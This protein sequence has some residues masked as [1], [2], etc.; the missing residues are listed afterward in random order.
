MR[1]ISYITM[2]VAV[3]TISAS[4][5]A[6]QNL[7]QKEAITS[8]EILEDGSVIIRLYAPKAESVTLYGDFAPGYDSASMTMTRTD[9]GVWEYRSEPLASELYYYWFNVDGIDHIV[10]P[11]N[12][13]VM[14]DVGSQMNYFI[15][16]GERGDLYSAQS[17]P[18][19]TV[20]KV[21]AKISDG[22]ERRMTVYTPAGYE[23]GRSKYPVLYLLH[24]MGGDEEAWI[25]T[26]RL[27]EI[28]DNL[29][30]QG[31]AEPMIVVMTNGCTNHVSAPGFS[32]EGMWRPYMSG[33]MDGSFERMFPSIVEWVDTHYRTIGKKSSRAIAGLSMG[34]FH[35]MQISK[36]YPTMFDYVGL[37][38]AAIF[39]GKEGVEIYDNLE[40]KLA[41]QFEQGVQKYW[42]AIGND[43]FLY[44]EN[45]RYRELLNSYGYSYE[46]RES[47]KGHIWRNWRIYIAEFAQM[48]FSN[49]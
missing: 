35:A 41:R 11:A 29:I 28:M 40:T 17:V 14:R 36:E 27:A 12:S 2:I 42:I 10:D 13:Y 37:F 1:F 21:W 7:W 23:G 20:S 46:Y 48:L 32:H 22:R 43:D 26:G 45:V 6:Q 4:S 24:G 33:S 38:S 8:P 5:M 44:E 9:D 25:A 19:G 18:H 47:D 39:R 3:M 34:G 15:I 31:K 16:P 49:K 30:A